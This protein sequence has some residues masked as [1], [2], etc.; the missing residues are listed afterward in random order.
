MDA[1]IDAIGI[2]TLGDKN[3][4]NEARKAYN[5]LNE[6]GRGFATK[7]GKLKRAEFILKALQTW[8][9]PVITIVNAALVITLIPSLRKKI[10]KGKKK[11]ETPTEN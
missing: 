2:V 4:I 9:I 11:E 7:E 1:L 10:F 5:A 3:R 8:G 6:A